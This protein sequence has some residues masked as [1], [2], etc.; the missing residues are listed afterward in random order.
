MRRFFS[1]GDKQKVKHLKHKNIHGN[2]DAAIAKAAAA[3]T[4]VQSLS[5]EVG[6]GDE[7][8]GLFGFD[9][10]SAETGFWWLAEEQEEVSK[11]IHDIDLGT[12]LQKKLENL[13]AAPDEADHACREARDFASHFRVSYDIFLFI[14]E[15]VKP[16]FSVCTHDGGC[17]Y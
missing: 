5:Q 12:W 8:L 3:V 16:V 1:L 9:L 14:M 4:H 6:S 2:C 13:C 10:S 7:G 11:P 15:A 17:A